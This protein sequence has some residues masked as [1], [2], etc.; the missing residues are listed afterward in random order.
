MGGPMGRKHCRSDR[1]VGRLGPSDRPVAPA[2]G[3][4]GPAPPWPDGQDRRGF[5]SHRPL[6]RLLHGGGYGSPGVLHLY[7]SRS[8]LFCGSP[9]GKAPVWAL[10]MRQTSRVPTFSMGQTASACIHRRTRLSTCNS[11]RASLS[12][13]LR[14]V[15][16]ATIRNRSKLHSAII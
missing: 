14:D 2:S 15:Y 6:Y 12:K 13:S 7:W 4:L 9:G 11:V 16:S 8:A 3:N 5:C 1:T 10:Q